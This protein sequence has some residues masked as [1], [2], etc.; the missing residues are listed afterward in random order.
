V[1]ENEA[2]QKPRF[3]LCV[4]KKSTEGLFQQ[5]ASRTAPGGVVALESPGGNGDSIP[6]KGA[7]MTVRVADGGL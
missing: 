7:S 4:L 5:T 6:A 3:S 1:F 2:K